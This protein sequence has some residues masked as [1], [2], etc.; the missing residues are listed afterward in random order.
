MPIDAEVEAAVAA[1]RFLVIA[2]DAIADAIELTSFLMSMWIKS[3][4]RSPATASACRVRY[5]GPGIGCRA[6]VVRQPN[7]RQAEHL[8]R[9]ASRKMLGVP[10]TVAT[11]VSVV[12][13]HRVMLE[14]GA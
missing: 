6:A 12:Y 2:G 10:E 7:A 3:P 11:R 5:S 13:H 8:Q 4:G 1:M 9:R 14:S